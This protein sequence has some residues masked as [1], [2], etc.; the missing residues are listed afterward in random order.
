MLW[1]ALAPLLLLLV[2]FAV[3][4]RSDAPVDPA[5]TKPRTEPGR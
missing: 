5:H 3:F 4:T 1:L 2:A